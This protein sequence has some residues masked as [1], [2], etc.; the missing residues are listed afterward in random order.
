MILY[1]GMNIKATISAY[2]IYIRSR[3]DASRLCDEVNMLIPFRKHAKESKI[4]LARQ[5]VLLPADHHKKSKIL[6]CSF[7][8]RFKRNSSGYLEACDTLLA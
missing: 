2:T 6:S 7:N 8:H 4:M 5:I 1:D 3:Y